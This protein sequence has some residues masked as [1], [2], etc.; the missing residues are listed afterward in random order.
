[1]G[2]FNVCVPVSINHS[3][4]NARKRVLIRF[5]LPYKVG[6][7]YCPGNSDEKL[8]CEAAAF[9]WLQENCS[10]AVPLPQLSGFGFPSGQSVR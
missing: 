4:D 8:R 3:V 5:P 10:R 1:V 7:S 9:L 6:E 2:S